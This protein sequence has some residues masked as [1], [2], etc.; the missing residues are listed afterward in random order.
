MRAPEPHGCRRKN[1]V[2]HKR[3][4]KIE[5]LWRKQHISKMCRAEKEIL[6]CQCS[7]RGRVATVIQTE[8]YIRDFFLPLLIWLHINTF[9]LST[10][11][12]GSQFFKGCTVVLKGNCAVKGKLPFPGLLVCV[13]FKYMVCMQPSSGMPILSEACSAP[14]LSPLLQ[15]NQGQRKLETLTKAVILARKA[16]HQRLSTFIN[17]H[18]HEL[19]RH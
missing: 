14:T 6:Q 13:C 8:Q 16:K 17:S 2:G 12:P 11:N 10:K 5:N 4:Q 18:L 3:T 7:L 1:V 19:Q 9:P 15:N